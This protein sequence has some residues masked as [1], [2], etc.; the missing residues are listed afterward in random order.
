MKDVDLGVGGG[1][2]VG[3]GIL[4]SLGS[5]V[6][7]NSFLRFSMTVHVELEGSTVDCFFCGT[8]FCLFLVDWREE[9]LDDVDTLCI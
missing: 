8:C 3:P 7:L 6:F 1:C 4:I 5:L 9:S 2:L